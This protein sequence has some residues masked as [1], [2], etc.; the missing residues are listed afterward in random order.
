MKK[1]YLSL[2]GLFALSINA[3]VWNWAAR[4]ND[5]T[6][7]PVWAFDVAIDN[8]GNI[9]TTNNFYGNNSICASTFTCSGNKDIFLSK[10]SSSGSCLWTVQ[11]GT[12]NTA[13][14]LDD[15]TTGIGVD[16]SGNVYIAGIIKGV[17]T[18]GD[19]TVSSV[20]T[21]SEDIF[22]A[23]YNSSGVL[24]WVRSFGSSNP[25]L[26]NDLVVD[27]NGDCYLTGN[28][29]GILGATN[30]S[31]GSSTFTGTGFLAKFDSNGNKQWIKN[32]AYQGNTLAIDNSS[33][34]YIAGNSTTFSMGSL[35]KIDTIIVPTLGTALMNDIYIAKFNSSGSALWAEVMGGTATDNPISIDV[36]ATGNIALTG[37]FTGSAMFGV[38]TFSSSVAA[39]NAFVAKLS[40]NGSVLWATQVITAIGATIDEVL[41]DGSGNIL[42][43]GGMNS[44]SNIGGSY[45]SPNGSI[46]PLYL[47]KFDG[48]GSLTAYEHNVGFCYGRALAKNGSNFVLSG[49]LNGS[50]CTFGSSTI[51]TS[52]FNTTCFLASFNPSNMTLSPSAIS[53]NDKP[54][55]LILAPNPTNGMM[56]LQFA[57]SYSEGRSI[58]V[59]NLVGEKLIDNISFDAHVSLDLSSLSSSIYLLNIQEGDKSVSKRVVVQH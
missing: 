17:A 57:T 42:F 16:N 55:E 54:I 37:T 49:S 13:S 8:S 36:D 47:A 19:S 51:S 31:F 52:G 10:Y 12:A 29:A 14:S 48:S 6:A 50:N 23:K 33:N 4:L 34:V 35:D 56:S 39:T 22:L 27:S 1:I 44:G 21:T 59:Y 32:A 40:T 28:M 3:Q 7:T 30:Y 45:P 46:S 24:Q 11:A 26:V 41:F 15:Q 9:F 2:F 25:D 18:F 38:N 58:S 20:P 5:N 43:T 53:A